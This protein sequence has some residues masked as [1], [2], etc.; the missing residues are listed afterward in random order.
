MAQ[1]QQDDFFQSNYDQP[2]YDMGG[3]NFGQEQ[4]FGQFDYNQG[5]V[6]TNSSPSYAGS[7]FTPQAPPAAY[8]APPGGPDDYENEPPLMEELGINFDHIIQKTLTVLNPMKS[9]DHSIMQDTDLAGP[10]VFCLAFGGSLMLSG[11]LHFGYIY[12]IGVVGCLAMYLLLNLMSLTGVSVGIIIS[13]FG[14]CL[15]PMVLLSFTSVVMSLQGILGLVFTIAT[16]LWC[17]ISASKLFVS[18][19][20]MDKQQLLVAY[21]CALV[22]GVFALLTVF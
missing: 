14:Y 19:L 7:I 10:L 3:A 12:G 18:A 20:A 15:L 4:Q 13:V 1:F 6:P 5:Y 2:G 9:A 16:V 21:P 8:S 11:K 22:Y 17:S